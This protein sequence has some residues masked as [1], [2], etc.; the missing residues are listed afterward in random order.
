MWG[1]HSLPHG[2]YAAPVTRQGHGVCAL[3]CVNWATSREIVRSVV[4][5][6]MREVGRQRFLVEP[7]PALAS[8][9]ASAALG[10]NGGLLT[11]ERN[12]RLN[13]GY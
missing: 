5:K 1:M 13:R 8:G 10:A 12:R 6:I 9:V 11:S 3:R 2:V 4:S 7:V